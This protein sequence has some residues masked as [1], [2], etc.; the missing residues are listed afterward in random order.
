MVDLQKGTSKETKA[1]Q[2]ESCPYTP[3][4]LDRFTRWVEQLPGQSW[5]FYTAL[6]LVLASVATAFDWVDGAY[7]IGTFNAFHI[8][9]TVQPS[10]TLALTRHLDGVAKKALR[11]IRPALEISEKEYAGLQYRLTTAPAR[12]TLQ[13]S[14]VGVAISVLVGFAVPNAYL[15]FGYT[16]LG[17]PYILLIVLNT[18]ALM[19]LGALVSHT[20]HQLKIVSQIYA[21]QAIVNLF[22]ISPLYSFSGLTSQ[23][24]VG[25]TILNSI[26]VVTMPQQMLTASAGIGMSILNAVI[27]IVTFTWP[28]LGIHSRLVREKQRMLRESSQRL[29]AT[30][31]E[32]HD[33]IDAG[34]LHSMNE[35]HVTISSLEI[36]QSII[37]KI[38]TWPWRPGTVRGFVSALLLP[39]VVFF[40]QYVLQRFLFS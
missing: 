35:L 10:F 27:S 13:G 33:R 1:D 31:N 5:I 9:L 11:N 30:L 19:V 22:D 38:P 40:L 8:W 34:E 16:T 2:N 17:P 3:S 29:E 12:P 18:F 37:T 20:I 28:L 36:E 39:L 26:W 7:P 32:L 15:V 24:A 6:G 25:F 4:W 14:L 21:K 23:T